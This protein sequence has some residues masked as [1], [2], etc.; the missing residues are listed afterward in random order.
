M[1]PS[2]GRRFS[3]AV[4]RSTGLP[5]NPDSR[6]RPNY[7]KKIVVDAL[8][9]RELI[10]PKSA[11]AGE[12]DEHTELVWVPTKRERLG[13]LTSHTPQANPKTPIHRVDSRV[14]EMLVVDFDP[15]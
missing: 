10:A 1:Y 5:A 13:G 2:I 15:Q 6:S 8:K 12:V 11:S 7:K 4:S 14:A 9:N 3:Q